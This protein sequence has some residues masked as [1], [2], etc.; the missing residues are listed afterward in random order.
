[1]EIIFELFFEFFGEII[2]QIVFQ[3]FAEFGLQSLQAPFQKA[4]NPF[5]AGAG[6]AVFGA[7]AGALSL[8]AFPASFIVSYGA[9]V[10]SLA[11]TPF[12]AGA[13]MTAMGAWRRKRGQ[14]LIRLD[15]FGYGYVFALAMALVRFLFTQ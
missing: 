9:R 15:R 6:Y 7:L 1:M 10:A 11:L 13:S 8:W 5:L 4:P 2:L 3:L 12:A 14:D